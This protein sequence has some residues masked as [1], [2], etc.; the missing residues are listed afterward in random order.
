[1]SAVLVL[2]SVFCATVPMLTFL[3]L[4]W[5]MDRH[6]REP[7]WLFGLT[8][9]WGA[10]G[11]TFLSLMGN[12]MFMGLAS[13]VVGPELGDALGTVVGAPLIEEPTKALILFAIM[14]SRHFD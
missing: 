3:A 12:G 13:A 7:L 14:F 1:M 9:L 11:A 6:D 10:L 8:F 2:L 4:V 5:W